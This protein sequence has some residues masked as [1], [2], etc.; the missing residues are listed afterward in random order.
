[1]L[2]AQQKQDTFTF[3]L[4]KSKMEQ[5]TPRLTAR[6]REILQLIALGHTS[7]II[8]EKLCL[9]LPTIKWYRKRLRVKFDVGTTVEMVRKALE[10]GLIE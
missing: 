4:S 1:M 6:E 9:S 10:A 7:E 2:P 8:A 5:S 3:T